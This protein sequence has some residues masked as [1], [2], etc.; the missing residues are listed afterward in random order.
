MLAVEYSLFGCNI[1]SFLLFRVSPSVNSY[2]FTE[3]ESL[4]RIASDTIKNRHVPGCCDT[5][6]YLGE[7][8]LALFGCEG[9]LRFITTCGFTEGL[10]FRA[11]M[12]F[13]RPFVAVAMPCGRLCVPRLG[14]PALPFCP[15]CACHVRT[16]PT[17]VVVVPFR[18]V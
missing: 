16:C 1:P 4:E 7:V 8:R 3:T 12:K 13:R 15:C 9:R 18:C 6:L 2:L 17:H 14:F 5:T 11:L 10:G